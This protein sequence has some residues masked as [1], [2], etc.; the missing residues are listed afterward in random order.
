MTPAALANAVKKITGKFTRQALERFEGGLTKAPTGLNMLAICDVLGIDYRAALYEHRIEWTTAP[1]IQ[2]IQAR[3]GTNDI[4]GEYRRV[5]DNQPD[6]PLLHVLPALPPA[7]DAGS[8]ENDTEDEKL[9]RH[10]RVMSDLLAGMTAEQRETQIRNA[11]ATER[12][13]DQIIKELSR[14]RTG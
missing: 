12:Q 10:Q 6:K 14:R 8:G 11:Q 13:N 9:K 2:E 5:T 1:P 7:E 4:Q 3:H